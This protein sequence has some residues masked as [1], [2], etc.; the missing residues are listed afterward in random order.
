M[1]KIEEVKSFLLWAFRLLL[2][3]TG[4]VALWIGDIENFLFVTLT[5][6]LT[7]LP[8]LIERQLR[9]EY[10]GELEILILFLIMSSMYLGEM[11]AYYY[12]FRWWD[13]LLHG[14]SAIIVGGIGFSLVFIL[15]RSERVAL[16]LSPKF[17][18]VFAF[19]FSLSVGTLWEIFEFAMDQLF[20]FNMQ[21]SGLIDTMW[22]LITNA[23]G[24]FLFSLVGYFHIRHGI[25]IFN[26][27]EKKF[28]RM[29]PD[30]KI[31]K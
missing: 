17:V 20:G 22:D 6:F 14:V 29:N 9:I 19:G 23:I 1:E 16:K 7:F 21:K 8:S 2:V 18:A 5:L 3:V 26:Y 12:K 28:F 24:A 10:P 27:L 4:I 25:T 30:L 13:T 15:N 31:K 11:H